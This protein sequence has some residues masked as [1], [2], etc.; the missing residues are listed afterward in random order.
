MYVVGLT[1]GAFQSQH[2]VP[3]RYAKAGPGHGGMILHHTGSDAFGCNA[4]GV[5]VFEP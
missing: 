4:N 5:T 2:Y 3:I 1:V